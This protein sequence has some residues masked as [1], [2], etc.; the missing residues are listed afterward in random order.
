MCSCRS[1]LER[2]RAFLRANSVSEVLKNMLVAITDASNPAALTAD[3]AAVVAA[4]TASIATSVSHLECAREQ[5][6]ANGVAH[7]LN[8]A[9]VFPVIDALVH[10]LQAD[11]TG[12]ATPSPPV[13]AAPP[14]S[15]SAA[16]AASAT[17]PVSAPV[18]SIPTDKCIA[19][20]TALG[21]MAQCSASCKARVKTRGALAVALECFK[22]SQ[23]K[24]LHQVVDKLLHVC[25]ELASS[26]N[27][28]AIAVDAHLL[29][30]VREDSGA[31]GDADA[32]MTPEPSVVE[33]A[34]FVAPETV[35]SLLEAAS[36]MDDKRTLFRLVRWLA[37]AVEA[38][39]NALALG[40]SAIGPLV[41]ITTETPPSDHV[42]MGF[43]SRC[44]GAI[45]EQSSSACEVRAH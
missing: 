34:P 13:A 29:A 38:P 45:V 23:D 5:L 22:V 14:A 8:E 37:T 21:R 6:E 43:L 12:A 7:N 28:K 35:V 25:A 11:V 20:V 41:R 27:D 9:A 33:R 16:A 36:T 40:E 2:G 17:P 1:P 42:L 10:V 32:F 24:R 31:G 3:D 15:T 19:I 39:A 26:D 18:L 44:I 4:N 30:A